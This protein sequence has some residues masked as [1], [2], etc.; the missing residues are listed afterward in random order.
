MCVAFSVIGLIMG[1]IS[2]A[3]MRPREAFSEDG[4]QFA[5]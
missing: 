3:G 1:A 5:R 2:V 4:I